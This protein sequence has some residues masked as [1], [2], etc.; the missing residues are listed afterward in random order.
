M[1]AS[2]RATRSSRCI[3]ACVTQRRRAQLRSPQSPQSSSL[4]SKGRRGSHLA[5]RS[6]STGC[7]AYRRTRGLHGGLASKP[8]RCHHRHSSPHRSSTAAP[9]PPRGPSAHGPLASGRS[10]PLL[11]LAFLALPSHPLPASTSLFCAWSIWRSMWGWAPLNCMCMAPCTHPSHFESRLVDISL[12][13]ASHSR[14]LDE[15]SSRITSSNWGTKPLQSLGN[16]KSSSTNSELA[17]SFIL[18]H[19]LTTAARGAR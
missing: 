8:A 3:L 17:S 9:L 1:A 12:C 16:T 10:G 11:P 18:K 4:S 2:K 6:R 15:A 14:L 13:A 5:A 19:G 7:R